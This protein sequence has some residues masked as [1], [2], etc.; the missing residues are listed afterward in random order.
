PRG[1]IHERDLK[2]YIY[3]PFGRDLLHNKAFMRSLSSFV[4]SCPVA[5]VNSDP[6]EILKI[7]ATSRDSDGI[8]VTENM[9]YVGVLSAAALLKVINEKRVQQA[10]DQN[11]LTELPGNLS[12]SDHVTV[13][14]LDSALMRHFCYFD[15]DNFKPFNDQYGFQHGDRAISLFAALLRRHLSGPDV[16]LGHVGGDDFFAGCAGRP[17][18]GL[19][20]LLTG[21]LEE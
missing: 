17:R 3:T 16:F 5:D 8:I 21:L 11:P 18:A 9:H 12:I 14:A 7:F 4:T 6:G 20:P 15:F 10:Q 2:E 19:E 1:I 13:T